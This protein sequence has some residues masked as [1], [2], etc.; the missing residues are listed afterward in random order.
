MQQ[1]IP[2]RAGFRQVTD[3]VYLQ[4]VFIRS[5]GKDYAKWASDP[6]YREE[7]KRWAAKSDRAIRET[8]PV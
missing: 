3:C 8:Q 1:C 4:R 6:A 2:S 5:L 7:R